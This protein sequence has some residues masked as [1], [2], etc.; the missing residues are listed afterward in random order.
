MVKMTSPMAAFTYFAKSHQGDTCGTNGLPLT[1]HSI[2]ILGRSQFLKSIQH[3]NLC[4]YLD[5]IRSKHE[6]TIIVMEY[7]GKPLSEKLA[8]QNICYDDVLKCFYQIACGL[9]HI[10]NLDF[11]MQTLEPKNVLIDELGNVKLFNYGMYYQTN[12]GEYVTFPIGNIRYTSPE[13]ILG[14]KDNILGDIWS[15]GLII[16]ELVFNTPL[17]SSLSLA[18]FTRKI[19]SLANTKNVLE[20]IARECNLMDKYHELNPIFRNLLESCLA[21]SPGERPY[22]NQILQHELFLE[23]IRNYRYQRPEPNECLLLQCSLKQIY[24]L[25]KLAGGD[26]NTELKAVGLIRNEAPI[27]SMPK[28]VLLNGQILGQPRSQSHMYDSRLE[29]LSRI[30]KQDYYPLVLTDQYGKNQYGAEMEMLPIVIRE[31][32]TEYQFHRVLLFTKLLKGFPYTRDRIIL[33]SQHDIPPLLRGQ[34][35]ACLLNVMEDKSFEAIDKFTP[36][37][38]DRQIEVDIPR[39]HQYDELLSSPEGHQKLKRILKAWVKAHPQYVYWQGLDSLTAPFLYLNFN[40]E[41]M[42]TVNIHLMHLYIQN[43]LRMS[44]LNSILRS[45]PQVRDPAQNSP[46]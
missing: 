10:D 5:I 18:Q 27:L 23:N 42:C 29:R 44:M 31:R 11:T 30:K 46:H 9:N 25:W 45:T 32:D 37:Q 20:K 24:Y 36:N 28:L 38:T 8:V 1:P 35:W 3:E 17:W 43:I 33:E 2:V 13:R 41:G 12:Q 22:P 21:V 39:C 34:I 16:A 6:R 14:S 15:L 19:L 40:N 26:V 4:E 7:V